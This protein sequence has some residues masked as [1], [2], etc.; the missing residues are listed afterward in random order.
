MM[1]ITP[2]AA[3]AD[4]KKD[5]DVAV[6]RGVAFL[7]SQQAGGQWSY[8]GYELGSTALAGLTLLECGVAAD[9]PC[10][11]KAA[12]A[13]RNK[14]ITATSTY[15]MSL[16][17]MFLDRLADPTD[18]PFIESMTVRLLAGQGTSGGWGYFCPESGSSEV[19]RLLKHFK[20]RNELVAGDKLPKIPKN[21]K[22]RDPS[23]LPKE[24]LQ[25]LQLINRPGSA[26]VAGHGDNSNTQFATLAL[27][28]GRRHGLPVERALSRIEARFRKSQAQNGGWGYHVQNFGPDPVGMPMTPPDTVDL[29][30]ATAAMTC[31]GL[32]GL[33]VGHGAAAEKGVKKDLMKDN[34]VKAGLLA[35]STAIGKP[36]DAEKLKGGAVGGRSFYYLWSLERVAV[37]YGLDTIGKKDWYTWGA[38]MLLATQAL[39]GSWNGT[40]GAGGV[41]TCFALLFLRRANLAQDLSAFLKGRIRDPAEVALKSGG[42]GAD[43]LLE[44]GK[45]LKPGIVDK[46]PPEE[47]SKGPKEIAGAKKPLALTAE[48]AEIAQMSVEFAKASPA[49]Q[50][51][52]LTTWRDTK[53]SK[54]TEALASA[55][56]L[57]KGPPKT[58]AR[59]ALAKRLTRMTAKTLRA[60]L[61]DE[62]LE[63][64]RAA[65]IATGM[66]KAKELIP[67]LIKLLDDAE[68]PVTQAALTSLRELTGQDF[69]PD[70][71]ATRAERLAAVNAWKAW[72]KKHGG[73]P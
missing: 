56:A 62:D 66:K 18:V 72:W 42:V 71:E 57:L 19:T 46:S 3:R 50:E 16:A 24:I 7:K 54:Y 61:E 36:G 13:V 44:Y 40:Y 43:K 67:E 22:P 63:I 10:I 38:E 70:P 21:K 34:A 5:V 47:K 30:A 48:E 59:E 25:Q 68:M 26:W 60:Q 58:K 15:Q 9:D 12:D 23:E 8:P 49:K 53:G 55:I 37:I 39:N 41:D 35:L 4:L 73:T 69:G 28:I 31:A 2:A 17:I 11:T 14:S 64:R 6:E 33:A 65:A 45:G 20:Q 29:N 32:L 1:G 52:L 51:D 27:W